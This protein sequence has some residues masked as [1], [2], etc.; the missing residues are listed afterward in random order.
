MR[1][2]NWVPGSALARICEPLR[3]DSGRLF[4]SQSPTELNDLSPTVRCLINGVARLWPSADVGRLLIHR[5][6]GSFESFSLQ[7]SILLLTSTHL[8]PH[9]FLYLSV[10]TL[11]HR[12]FKTS[13]ELFIVE[14]V[15]HS[16]SGF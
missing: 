6:I 2:A 11:I 8:H 5:L 15:E 7:I 1:A 3:R 10:L 9:S 13:A 16:A 4:H 12:F 14:F